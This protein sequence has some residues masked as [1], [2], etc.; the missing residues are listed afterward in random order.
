MYAYLY[1]TCNTR[2]TRAKNIILLK[3]HFHLCRFVIVD[4]VNFNKSL[5]L[6]E[7]DDSVGPVLTV[8]QF[9]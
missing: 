4:S 9:E 1:A 7:F 5:E 3:L 6:A 8:T 2:A